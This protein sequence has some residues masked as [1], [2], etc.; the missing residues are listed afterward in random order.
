LVEEVGHAGGGELRGCGRPRRGRGTSGPRRNRCTSPSGGRSSSAV[1]SSAQIRLVRGWP[2]AVPLAGCSHSSSWLLARS[3]TTGGTARA[4]SPTWTFL[5]EVRHGTPSRRRSYRG[6]RLDWWSAG[7]TMLQ[8]IELCQEEKVR[9]V[10]ISRPCRGRSG[11]CQPSSQ[12]PFIASACGREGPLSRPGVWRLPGTVPPEGSPAAGPR[13][14]RSP[15]ASVE[16]GGAWRSEL[17]PRESHRPARVE[18]GRT[19]R[20]PGPPG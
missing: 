5:A 13:R 12:A 11:A 15:A 3:I 17:P 16:P 4:P 9:P 7:Q 14:V 10:I 2:T 20:V 19:G 18:I 8:G 1:P 6:C